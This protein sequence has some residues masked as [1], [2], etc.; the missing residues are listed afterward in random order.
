MALPVVSVVAGM[1]AKCVTMLPVTVPSIVGSFDLE[2]H[3]LALL[4]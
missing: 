3:H 4:D 1:A 2:P